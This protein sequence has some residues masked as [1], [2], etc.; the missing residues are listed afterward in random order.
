MNKKFEEWEHKAKLLGIYDDFEIDKDI[1]YEYTTEGLKIQ[2]G[3]S[4]NLAKYRGKAKKLI[5]PPVNKIEYGA[6]EMNNYI[7]EIIIP[8]NVKYVG[9]ACFREC[10]NLRKVTMN[11]EIS[12]LSRY[13]FN[14][15]HRLC[16][17]KLPDT[18]L[19]IDREAFRGCIKLTNINIPKDVNQIYSEV[20]RQSGIE[21]LVLND[22]LEFMG[23]DIIKDC[24]NLKRIIMVKS[25][26]KITEID[27]S[28]Y[29]KYLTPIG[30]NLAEVYIDKEIEE[31]MKDKI[32]FELAKCR[33]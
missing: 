30:I 20:F 1:Y 16:E 8:K 31:Y 2:K 19:S 21:E 29:S 32:T 7:E 14:R 22:N 11:C 9:F 3:F 27:Y 25:N 18:L 23:T 6:F 12:N 28:N 33:W 5:V 10:Y 24:S 15:C 13:I 26:S 17:I 4:Y